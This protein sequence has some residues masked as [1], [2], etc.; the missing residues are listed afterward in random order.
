MR[1]GLAL[2]PLVKLA[3]RTGAVLLGI[4]HFNK[5]GGGR[6][7]TDHRVGCVQGRSQ[8]SVWVRPR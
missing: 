2:D 5:G 6:G 1:C 4:A 7:I 3:D 8:D